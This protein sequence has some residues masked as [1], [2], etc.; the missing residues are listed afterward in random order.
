MDRK[1]HLT[2][3]EVLLAESYIGNSQ[4]PLSVNI[5]KADDQGNIN[6]H[7]GT[8]VNAEIESPEID[9]ELSPC[10]CIDFDQIDINDYKNKTIY[11]SSAVELFEFLLV[12]NDTINC[13]V[14]FKG[15]SWRVM[16]V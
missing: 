1:L 9:F 12:L 16:I 11:T 3:I 14:D 2:E 13:L 7:I 8:N 15:V 10:E 5:T 4:S 6:L